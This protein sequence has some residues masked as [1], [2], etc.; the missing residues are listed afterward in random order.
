MTVPCCPEVTRLRALLDLRETQADAMRREI[1]LLEEELQRRRPRL[2][3]KE[4]CR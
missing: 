3:L 2:W 1:A 4:D